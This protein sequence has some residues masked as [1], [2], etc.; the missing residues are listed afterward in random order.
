[1]DHYLGI[2][3]MAM[4]MVAL[5]LLAGTEFVIM[6]FLIVFMS[7]FKH[8]GPLDDVSGLSGKRKLLTVVLVGVFVLAFPM[9]VG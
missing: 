7:M 9:R 1:M 8:P 5:L 4:V 3:A 6:A 2:M